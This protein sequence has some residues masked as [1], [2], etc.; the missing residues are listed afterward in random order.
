M[1]LNECALGRSFSMGFRGLVLCTRAEW[2]ARNQMNDVYSTYIQGRCQSSGDLA[3]AMFSN[4][5]AHPTEPG[6]DQ[7]IQK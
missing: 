3:Q 2:Q 1:G 4:V 7:N 5:Y 6:C